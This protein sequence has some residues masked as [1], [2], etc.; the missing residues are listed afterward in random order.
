[1]KISLVLATLNRSKT[2]RRFMIHLRDQEYRN[3][4]LIIVDQSDNP[5]RDF[6]VHL[7]EEFSGAFCIKYVH[8]RKKGLS[9]ARNIGLAQSEGDLVGFP[10]DDCWYSKR[11]L[12]DV[13]NVFNNNSSFGYV[14]G[15]YTEPDVLNLS[16]SQ[17]PR[18]LVSVGD[19]KYGS[20]VT[21]FIKKNEGAQELWFDENLG[22]GAPLPAGEETELMLRLILHGL[23]GLYDPKICAFHAIQRGIKSE[24]QTLLREKAFG[25]WLGKHSRDPRVF[26]HLVGGL[27]K[28]LFYDVVKRNNLRRFTA[29]INGICCAAANSRK[30]SG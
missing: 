5:E 12:S 21:L 22:A 2:L 11:F 9:A 7:V 10:D 3:F 28:L 25:Y 15:Q 8:S 19:A 13:V 14:C 27:G 18:N 1:M 30:S 26:F 6:N 17:T 4:E 29:R 24:A 20:S 23:H 16:F